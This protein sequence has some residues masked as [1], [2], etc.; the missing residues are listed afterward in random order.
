M[1]ADLIVAYQVVQP[2]YTLDSTAKVLS[3]KESQG[4]SIGNQ[5]VS[6]PA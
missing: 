3:Q 5:D 2:L 4:R 1:S 6:R